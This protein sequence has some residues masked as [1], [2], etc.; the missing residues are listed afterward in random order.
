M[1]MLWAYIIG[2]KIKLT[3]WK[4]NVKALVAPGRIGLPTNI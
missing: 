3:K 2:D 4:E 1:S